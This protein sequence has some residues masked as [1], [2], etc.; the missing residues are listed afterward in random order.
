MAELEGQ[1][2]ALKAVM[3]KGGD[4][5]V[6]D[7]EDVDKETEAVSNAPASNRAANSDKQAPPKKNRGKK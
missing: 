7:E 1:L 4:N 2:T 3:I 5:V 6:D